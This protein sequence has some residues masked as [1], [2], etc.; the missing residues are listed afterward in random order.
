[1]PLRPLA[2]PRERTRGHG[3][4]R[5]A[6]T[7]GL[8]QKR[9]RRE[10]RDSTRRARESGTNVPRIQPGEKGSQCGH[11]PRRQGKKEKPPGQLL[12]ASRRGIT[13]VPREKRAD[14]Q[15]GEDWRRGKGVVLMREGKEFAIGTSGK[16][17]STSC[18]KAGGTPF[19]E[20]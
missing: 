7:R 17:V 14:W 11:R 20:G 9:K 2:A 15:K 1:M 6:P 19:Q 8:L 5:H 13:R 18:Q 10:K 16:K 3:T 12:G 4:L